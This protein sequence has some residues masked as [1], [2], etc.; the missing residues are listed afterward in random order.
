MT[1]S[2]ILVSKL[3]GFQQRQEPCRWGSI[4]GATAI[5]ASGHRYFRRVGERECQDL[6]R[7]RQ[8]MRWALHC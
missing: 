7:Q 5:G 2:Q 8:S 4:I 1:I 6:S 3:A